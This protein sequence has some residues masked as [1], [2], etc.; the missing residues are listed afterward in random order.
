MVSLKLT[1]KLKNQGV[2]VRKREKV[3]GPLY[4]EN[5]SGLT[6]KNNRRRSQSQRENKLPDAYEHKPNWVRVA[7]EEWQSHQ[8]A[9]LWLAIAFET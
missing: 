3:T 4:K 7:W 1:K 9:M 6:L 5:T 8:D 2:R